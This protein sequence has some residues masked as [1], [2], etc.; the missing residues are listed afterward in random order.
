MNHTNINAAGQPGTRGT[1]WLR[2]AAI[3]LAALVMLG[4]AA[5]ADMYQPGGTTPGGVPAQAIQ[6]SPVKT[7]TNCTFSWYGMRGWSTVFGSTNVSGPFTNFIVSTEAA[8]YAW[9]VTA[10][11]PDSSNSWFFV[12][13]QTNYYI[14]SGACSGCHGDKYVTWVK[15]AHASAFGAITNESVQTN[16]LV[17]R[18]VGYHQPTG[19]TNSISTPQLEN[20]GCES[21]HGPAGW[22]KF[23]DH[24]IIRPAV[25]IASE[26]CG[27]CH[28]TT[29]RPTYLEWTNSPHAEVV[30]DFISSFS[31]TLNGQLQMMKCGP[32]H[33]G[34]VRLAMLDD[35]QNRLGGFTNALTLPSAHDAT[36]YAQTCAVCHDPHSASAHY[37][38]TNVV[39]STN[40][41][42]TT[43][44]FSNYGIYH[45]NIVS[46][47]NVLFATNI[48]ATAHQ[49]RNSMN[50]TN[51][52]TFF[53]GAATNTV[54]TT[55]WNGIVT[56]IVIMN[57]VFA[58]QYNPNIQICAQC[59]NTRGARWDGIGRTWNGSNFVASTPSWSRPPHNTSQYNIL[60][61][62]VQPDY[63]NVNGSGVA[64]NFY[65]AHSGLTTRT[66]YNTN[67][68][69][70]CH[71][72]IYTSGG[73]NV[74]GHTFALNTNSCTICHGSVPNWLS[75][76]TNTILSIS[77]VVILL[78]QW[79]T[80]NGPALFGTNYTN[81]LQN[82][83]EYTTPGSL[84]TITNG[85]PSSTDQKKLPDAI[86]Q[87]RFDLYMV[88]NDGSFGVHN[89][90]YITFLISDAANKASGQI[91]PA[92]FAASPANGFTPLTVS[93][94]TY[95]T[96]I[97]GYNWSFGDGT[98]TSTSANPTYTYTTT[99][100]NAV[101]L[102]VTNGGGTVTMTNY[103]YTYA[104]PVPIFT[105]NPTTGKAPLTVVFTNLT[106]A[107]PVV[108]A[109][110]WTFMG[111]VSGSPTSTS[112]NP[113]FTFTNAGTYS[114]YLRATATNSPAGKT[115]TVTT[116]NLNY[117]IVTP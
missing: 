55:N 40:V 56:N 23:S 33:S 73:T 102:T 32:C 59:H 45:T 95:G 64:T 27:G 58:G 11:N 108:S 10:A 82:A 100:T 47:T 53:T 28:S 15:T 99:G 41:V 109:W 111:G 29:N 12:L 67:Q 104:P 68:C 93:F 61:G 6:N 38:S 91:N 17:F 71:V 78:N 8:D 37:E 115:G 4:T 74:T 97:T 25:T 105:G 22:H 49:L 13:A 57:D 1:A 77:N 26:V 35:Y 90:G 113:S 46:T 72:P 5:H 106:A 36:N 30:P 60:I 19:F 50:S 69:S 88:Q 87:A 92:Y 31:D 24:A 116:T 48:V 83:W 86:K 44:I 80:N 117:I 43:N 79:A 20:V 85:G 94:S 66:P 3:G 54:Y 2:P 96:G 76:Q 101:I 89:P 65:A 21:C 7:P 70:T 51:Y 81:Y 52:F 39:S 62:I 63:L 18:T 103:I 107:T 112:K 110:R 9:S 14:G 16:D 114:V 98:G 75:T 34:A 84:A 42:T